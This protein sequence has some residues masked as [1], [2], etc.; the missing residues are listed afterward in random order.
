MVNPNRG[1]QLPER[2]T[3]PNRPLTS[4]D[5]L[6]F[7]DDY[8]EDN[9]NRSPTQANRPA[10]P[11]PALNPKPINPKLA[12]PLNLRSSTTTTTSAT[13]PK[14]A[15]SGPGDTGKINS[16]LIPIIECPPIINKIK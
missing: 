8:P 10:N 2:S 11:K 5:S 7:L 14:P 6:P 9:Y 3:L 1:Q 12:N 16:H 15:Q 4:P 13:A